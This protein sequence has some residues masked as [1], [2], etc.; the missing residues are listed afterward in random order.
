ME[1]TFEASAA[2]LPPAG[3]L[4]R[5]W[6]AWWEARHERSDTLVLTQRNVYILPTRAG[7][8]FALTLIV[9]LLASINYQLNLGYLLTF[10]LAGSGLMSMHV[11]HATLRGL[12]LQLRAPAPVFAGDAAAIDIVLANP[13][14]RARHGI[15]L[16]LSSAPKT[17]RHAAWC[18]VPAGGQSSVTLGFVVPHRGWSPLPAIALET[19][20]PLGLFRAWSVWRP[21]SNVLAY[22]R[23]EHPAAPLPGT[24]AAGAGQGGARSSD[25]GE[26]EG[27]RPYRRGDPLKLVVWKKAARQ[28]DSGAELIVRDTRSAARHELWLEWAATGATTPDDRLA[29]LAAWV[30]AADR[31]GLA[32][33]LRLPGRELPLGQGEAQRR[34]GL[35]ALA[36]W[37]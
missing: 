16:G 28:L 14:K 34:A 33:G 8:L 37:S 23:P 2:A 27:I 4:R 12:N 17:H 6:N 15:A 22:P 20:Y 1:S 36:L 19:L 11:T 25:G 3:P 29:R 21:A 30:L 13:S 24:R 32:W 18:D 31:L 5:R 26:F 10:L 7:W 35:E 9:L